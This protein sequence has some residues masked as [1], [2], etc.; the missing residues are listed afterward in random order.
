MLTVVGGKVVHGTGAYQGMAP[1]LPPAAPDW[2]PV[3]YYG[4]YQHA[5]AELATTHALAAA[6]SCGH[7]CAIHGHAHG[8]TAAVLVREEELSGFWGALGCSCWAV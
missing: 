4:G 5:G 7:A 2:S 1:P 8:Q 3:G 6:C